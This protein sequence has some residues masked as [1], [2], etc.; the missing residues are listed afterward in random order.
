MTPFLISGLFKSKKIRHGFTLVELLVVIAIIGILVAMLLPAVQSAREAARRSHCQ[1]KLKQIGLACLSHESVHG[2]L[3]AGVEG[4]NLFNDDDSPGSKQE[5]GMSWGIAILPYIEE[6]QTYDLFDFSGNNNYLTDTINS[7][8]VTNR[9][10]GQNSLSIYVCPND[11]YAIEPFFAHGVEWAASSYRAVAGS[12]DVANQGGGYVWWDRL[13]ANN[14]GI[15]G[16]KEYSDYRGALVASNKRIS[17]APTRLSQITDGTSKSALV[18]EFHP[19]EG[20]IRRNVWASGWRYHNKGHFIRDGLGRSSIYRTSTT[21]ECRKSAREVPPGLGGEPSLCFRSFSTVHAGGII[22][23]VYCDGSIHSIRDVIDDDVY[24][25][26][27][28]IAGEEVIN[29]DI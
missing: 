23:F 9:E 11:I 13:N 22:Q 6:Q 1:N 15:Q 8:G 18:G 14:V 3:P 20:A 10:A 2:N 24:L 19:G 5:V 7:S 25:A 16:R 21:E 12:I 29:D 17:M 28:T 4:K 26:L 27:G